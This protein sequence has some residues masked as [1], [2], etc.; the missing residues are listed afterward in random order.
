[1]GWSLLSVRVE[2]EGPSPRPSG[3]WHFQHSSFWKSSWPCLMD[4]TVTLGSAGT[5]IG[6][7]GLSD[8]KRGEKVLMNA[9]RSARCWPVSESHDGML[10]I[11][12]PRPT[13]LYRSW[14]VGKVPVGVERHLKTAASK[15]RG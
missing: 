4:S 1:M 5:F 10:D 3:P 8:L 9:T 13:E 11:T 7:P 12:K 2:A 15:F 6:S 14:S